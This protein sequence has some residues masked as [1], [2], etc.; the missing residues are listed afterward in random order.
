MKRLL[1]LFALSS[2]DA[3][4]D[5]VRRT[6]PVEVVVVPPS[7]PTDSGW[8]VSD[9][10]GQAS[11]AS[12][13]FFAGRVLVTRRLDLTSWLVASAHAHPGHYEAGA[14]LAEVLE[15][16]VVDLSGRAVSPWGPAS[17]V[18]G[19][20]GSAELGWAMGVRVQGAATRGAQTVRFDTGLLTPQRPLTAIA[21]EHEVTTAPGRVR[22][23]LDL[24]VMLSRIDLERTLATADARGVVTFDRASQAFN[25]FDRG[26]TDTTAYRFTWQPD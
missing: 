13:R 24:G 19:S 23:T 7:A 25:G 12:L 18:T 3:S 17:A 14:A 20:Y 6:F 4:T 15:P 2:C 9:V 8:T 26:V 22:L 16:L 5:Q 21:F 11:F 1:C 10:S